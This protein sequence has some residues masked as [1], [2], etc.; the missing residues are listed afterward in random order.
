MELGL[1]RPCFNDRLT[2]VFE[3]GGSTR[4]KFAS[5]VGGGVPASG[6]GAP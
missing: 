6:F 3:V 1:P 4:T 5:Q 2:L